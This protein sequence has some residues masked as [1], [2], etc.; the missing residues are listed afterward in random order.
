MLGA[1]AWPPSRAR[2]AHGLER[3]LERGQ[4]VLLSRGERERE[5]QASAIG[6]QV[7]LGAD[8]AA[9][10]AERVVLRLLKIPFL[11]APAAE[12]LARM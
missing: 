1:S 7:D 11:P 9:R 8:A 6:Q 2:Q 4:F 10:K 3:P 12:G 5:W